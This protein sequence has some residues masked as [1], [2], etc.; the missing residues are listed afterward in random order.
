MASR[1]LL[2][3]GLEMH[4]D[5]V[6]GGYSGGNK[7]KLSLALALVGNP[8]V[9]FLDEPSSGM[10]PVA[11]RHMWDTI[12]E[13]TQDR[14]MVLT[15]HYMDECEALCNRIAIMVWQLVS[16]MCLRHFFAKAA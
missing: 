2:N 13:N 8:R 14:S 5:R 10:D 6:A 7:R 4:A 12:V 9:L 16:L 11:R 3:V 1:L 15:T